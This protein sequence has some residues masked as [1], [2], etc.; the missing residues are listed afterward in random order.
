ME[1][2]F[3]IVEGA[4]ELFVLIFGERLLVKKTNVS[5]TYPQESGLEQKYADKGY[6]L[7]WIQKTAIVGDESRGYRTLYI[8]NDG[9]LRWLAVHT[10]NKDGQDLVLM[11]KKTRKKDRR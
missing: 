9:T 3:F 7:K 4:L 11:K 5:F 2:I 8:K 10:Q 6:Q 1:V